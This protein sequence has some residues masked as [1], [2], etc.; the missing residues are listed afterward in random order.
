MRLS[1][2][3]FL[4]LHH[5]SARACYNLFNLFCKLLFFFSLFPPFRA[6]MPQLTAQLRL[7]ESQN[8]AAR[9]RRCG[10]CINVATEC[11]PLLNVTKGCPAVHGGDWRGTPITGGWVYGEH[12]GEMGPLVPRLCMM[13]PKSVIF[14]ART[15]CGAAARSVWGKHLRPQ[16]RGMP[17]SFN[18]FA[19]PETRPQ[20]LSEP[21]NSNFFFIH[22]PLVC[23][24]RSLSF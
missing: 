21:I 24:L 18:Y 12:A 22:H 23:L 11:R 20:S 8:W 6:K 2:I 7:G 19:A 17:N 10:A 5:R 9:S 13:K 4:P 15:K 1:G 14:C 16:T 3:L